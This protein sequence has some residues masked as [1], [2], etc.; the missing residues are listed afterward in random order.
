MVFVEVFLFVFVEKHVLHVEE[1]AP[2]TEEFITTMIIGG[3]G[4]G[5]L[6]ITDE[7]LDLVGV[8]FTPIGDATI[9]HFLLY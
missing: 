3:I 9:V 1:L 7:S 8:V 5:V 4:H 2:R 6:G